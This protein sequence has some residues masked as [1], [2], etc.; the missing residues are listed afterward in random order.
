MISPTTVTEIEARFE[1]SLM[2]RIPFDIGS[3]DY[4][5][6]RG[7][8]Y[9]EIQPGSGTYE[10]YK[11]IHSSVH[12]GDAFK[13][14]IELSHSVTEARHDETSI[15]GQFTG[16]YDVCL[17]WISGATL[18]PRLWNQSLDEGG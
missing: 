13:T 15:K 10:S 18:L 5:Q 14:S 9:I 11:P 4:Y 1:E 12:D 16:I 2:W 7:T 6:R 17:S 8:L 3:R